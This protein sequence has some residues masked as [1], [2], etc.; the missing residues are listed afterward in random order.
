LQKLKKKKLKE[1]SKLRLLKQA[2][3]DTCKSAKRTRYMEK[4]V[5]FSKKK[6]KK[7]IKKKKNPY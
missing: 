1:K 4:I 6:K 5:F 3:T 7:K 2:I